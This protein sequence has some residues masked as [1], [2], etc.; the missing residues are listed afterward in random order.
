M[1]TILH[2]KSLSNQFNK[3]EVYNQWA[4]TYEEYVESIGYNGPENFARVFCD[5]V[6]KP[7]IRVLD[8]GCGTGLLGNEIKNLFNGEMELVG[9][10]ISENMI[11]NA[12]KKNCYSQIFNCNLDEM[13][14]NEIRNLLG[15]FD[16]IVSCGVFLEG[17]V[18]FHIFEKLSKLVTENIIFTVRES[19]MIEDYESYNKYVSNNSTYIEQDIDYL[20][21]VRCKLVII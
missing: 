12:N 19:Y 1:N 16:Y 21:N 4:D 18:G 17:H 9:V 8:F 2:N 10:D 11:K 13:E 7:H 3:V 5:L 14:L 20:D 15:T 6:K